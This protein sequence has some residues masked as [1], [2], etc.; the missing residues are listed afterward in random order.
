VVEAGS[1]DPHERLAGFQGGEVFDAYLNDL[2]AAWATRPRDAPLSN[3]V[4]SAK[5]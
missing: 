5:S 1:L 2:W 3:S 4:H